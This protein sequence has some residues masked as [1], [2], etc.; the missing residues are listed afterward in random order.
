MKYT[1]QALVDL[2]TNTAIEQIENDFNSYLEILR[3]IIPKKLYR[4][5]CHDNQNI[6]LIIH[7][8]IKLTNPNYYND[9]YDSYVLNSCAGRFTRKYDVDRAILAIL[10]TSDVRTLALKDELLKENLLSGEISYA[11]KL[12]RLKLLSQKYELTNSLQINHPYFNTDEDGENKTLGDKIPNSLVACFSETNNDILMWGHYAKSFTGMCVEYKVQ[13]IFDAVKRREFF[14]VPV[15]YTKHP[16]RISKFEQAEHCNNILWN[17]QQ[18]MYKSEKWEYEVEWR[19]VKFQK[20]IKQNIIELKGISNIFLGY[21]FEYFNK[22]AFHFTYDDKIEQV[23]EKN[24]IEMFLKLADFAKTKNIGIIMTRP[25]T[26]KF[27]YEAD[28]SLS[29]FM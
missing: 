20:N 22:Y 15:I 5:Y 8:Q 26:D 1:K 7:E 24:Q 12:V 29:L 25:I 19:I 23:S 21:R 10:R 17:L 4:Y 28:E 6:N 9:P 13:E 11:K 16:Y 14:L 27:E 3:N 18:F 2:F